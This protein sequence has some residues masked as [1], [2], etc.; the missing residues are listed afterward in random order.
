MAIIVCIKGAIT[1]V[2][3]RTMALTDFVPQRIKCIIIT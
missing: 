2:M 1:D 3:D